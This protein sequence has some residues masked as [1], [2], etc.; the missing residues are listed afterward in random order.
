MSNRGGAHVGDRSGDKSLGSYCGNLG[1]SNY[2][3]F[4]IRSSNFLHGGEVPVLRREGVGVGPGQESFLL[5]H[6]VG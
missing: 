5:D 6:S 2:V 1:L 4:S 3:L